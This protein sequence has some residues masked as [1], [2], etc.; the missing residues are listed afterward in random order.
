MKI[1]NLPTHNTAI[2]DSTET[3]KSKILHQ[4]CKTLSL[5]ILDVKSYEQNEF[6]AGLPSVR[7]GITQFINLH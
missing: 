4:V 6:C 7:N 5:P 3:W 2:S 1:S